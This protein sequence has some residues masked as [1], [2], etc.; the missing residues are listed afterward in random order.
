MR[1]GHYVGVR[2]KGI[3]RVGR[4]I[5]GA[6]RMRFVAVQ[7]ATISIGNAVAAPARDS[8]WPV[9]RKPASLRD[10]APAHVVGACREPRLLPET[11]LPTCNETHARLSISMPTSR[12]TS[13][14]ASAAGLI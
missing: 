11:R 8:R 10:E 4:R 2:R 1:G 5:S 13:A 6:V 14:D 12:R 9:P 7:N 3:R